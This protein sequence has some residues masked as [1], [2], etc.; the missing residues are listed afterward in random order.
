MKYLILMPLIFLAGCATT[1]DF[2][3]GS[4]LKELMGGPKTEE[5]RQDPMISAAISMTRIGVLL[6]A[7]GL[8]FGAVTRFSTGWGLSIAAAGI[9]MILLAWTFRQAWVPWVGLGTIVA[10]LGY[11]V[12]NRLNPNVETENFF[13]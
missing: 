9:L 7:G 11:K 12:Y 4:P 13:K 6:L 5:E 2:S 10:Y 3:Q 1:P 8:I